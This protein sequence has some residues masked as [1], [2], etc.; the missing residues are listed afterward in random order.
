MVPLT[1]R[2][3]LSKFIQSCKHL[4][5][6]LFSKSHQ[7]GNQDCHQTY[8]PVTKTTVS[9]MCPQN[10]PENPKGVRGSHNVSVQGGASSMTR[11]SSQMKK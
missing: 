1:V 3:G 9:A 6:E 7:T 8:Q 2:A 5:K 10:T 11:W 4:L